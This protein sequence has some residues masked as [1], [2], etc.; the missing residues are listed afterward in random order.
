MSRPLPGSEAKSKVV[1]GKALDS[2]RDSKF[3]LNETKEN[4]AQCEK[5]SEHRISVLSGVATWQSHP[6][7]RNIFELDKSRRNGDSTKECE[8]LASIDVEIF[9][10]HENAESLIK[11]AS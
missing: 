9:E 10:S 7:Y 1:S 4:E 3:G 2:I 6:K 5:Y 8:S 11:S